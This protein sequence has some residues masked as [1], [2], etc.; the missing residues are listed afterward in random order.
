MSVSLHVILGTGPVGCWIAHALCDMGHEVRAINRTGRRSALMPSPVDVVAADA[1]DSAALIAATGRASVIYQALNPAYHRWHQD[2]PALQS[3]ALDAAHAAH[4][5]YVSI[6]NL[7][8]YDASSTMTEDS[9]VA[10]RSR[11]G[12][13]RARMA[14]EVWSAHE[15]GDVRVAVLR[16]SDYF[17][18]GVTVSAM[19]DMV[20]GN[21][22]KKKKAQVLG[23]ATQPHSWAYIEDVGR[24]AAMLGTSEDALGHTWIAPH[25]APRTQ[26][27]MVERACNAMGVPMRMSVISPFMLRLAGL[28]NAGARE[29]V[30]MSYEFTAP[31][32]V[33]S[34]RIQRTFAMSPTPLD[35]A[36]ERTVRWYKWYTARGGT[37]V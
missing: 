35:E 3:S 8:M 27:E 28:F 1:F 5:R 14:E 18:P 15:L 30:E 34:T 7:Y 19:A 9:P 37:P 4:A 17:G 33:N 29:M 31:F 2:F 11:K 6:D 24:A 23:S 10:P 20:F 13:L 26:R 32:V 12:A 25:A 21:L 36:I 22:L 16:S